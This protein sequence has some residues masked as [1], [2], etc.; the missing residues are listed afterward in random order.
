[1]GWCNAY[2]V[3]ITRGERVERLGGRVLVWERQVVDL[4]LMGGLRAQ[5]LEIAESAC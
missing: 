5:G 1:M 4:G 3:V 2:V